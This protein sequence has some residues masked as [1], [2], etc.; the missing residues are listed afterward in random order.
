MLYED[1]AMRVLITGVA[2]S[3]GRLLA[4][5]F[6]GDPGVDAVTGLDARAC[7][8]PVRGMR[9]VRADL[10]QPE[11]Q[12]LLEQVDVAVHIVG[13]MWPLRRAYRA[14]DTVVVEGSKRFLHAVRTAEV[15]KVILVSSAM[16]YGPQRGGLESVTESAPVH[17]HQTSAYARV[18]ALLSDYL[19]MMMREWCGGVLTRLRVAGVCGPR[20]LSLIQYFS[21]AP[22]LA[23]GYEHRRLSV[24][25]E[26]DLSAV[27]RLAAHQDLPGVYNVSAD[28][29]V[30]FRELA[31]LVGQNRAC[32]PLIVIALHAWLRWRWLGQRTPP[33]WIQS[34]YRALPVD[35]TKLKA[36]GW[37]PQYAPRDV[38]SE[39][40]N[41]WRS[42]Q[43]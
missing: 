15:P 41:A 6:I 8:P 22:V 23:C 14:L 40:L 3:T 26:E 4:E 5:R 30:T 32:V 18:R 25:H 16:V 42:D 10:R 9:F 36:T 1:S 27:V 38:L 39:A 28:G 29:G 21:T 35:A 20:H 7:Y 37:T 13:T 17:G 43:V 11:W 34:L 24:L 2:G 31:A 33:A 19:D 12:P